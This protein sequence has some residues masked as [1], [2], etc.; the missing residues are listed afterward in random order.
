M[1]KKKKQRFLV[2]TRDNTGLVIFNDED[3][4]REYAQTLKKQGKETKI[5]IDQS[6]DLSLVQEVFTE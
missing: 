6:G 5:S 3:S 2:Q 4:A 1:A